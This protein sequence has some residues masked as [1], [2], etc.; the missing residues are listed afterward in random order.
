MQLAW[1]KYSRGSFD[2]PFPFA[3]LRVGVAQD[4]KIF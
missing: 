2:S 1:T 4:D 3:T